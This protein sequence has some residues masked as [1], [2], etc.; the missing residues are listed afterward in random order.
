LYW[1][2][3]KVVGSVYE[4]ITLETVITTESDFVFKMNTKN[5]IFLCAGDTTEFGA[6][7]RQS[8]GPNLHAQVVSN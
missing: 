4:S 7:G 8:P 5:I 3:L 2:F 6:V 1:I